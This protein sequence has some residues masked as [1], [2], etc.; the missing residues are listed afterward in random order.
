MSDIMGEGWLC[1][2]CNHYNPLSAIQC[3]QCGRVCDFADTL[4]EWKDLAEL[5]KIKRQSKRRRYFAHRRR[6][7]ND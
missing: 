2:K 1:C 4:E 6:G 5:E 3:Q 7:W